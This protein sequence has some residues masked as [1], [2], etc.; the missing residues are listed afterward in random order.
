MDNIHIGTLDEWT[1]QIVTLMIFKHA[2]MTIL[3]RNQPI[4]I[5]NDFPLFL[6]FLLIFMNTQIMQI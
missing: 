3:G 2:T 5:F 6:A 4:H 1:C